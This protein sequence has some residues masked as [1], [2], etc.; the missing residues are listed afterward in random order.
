MPEHCTRVLPGPGQASRPLGPPE[1]QS[2]E[3]AL[4]QEGGFTA[5]GS[6]RG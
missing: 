1:A 3:A 6:R 2:Y 4:S 5:L